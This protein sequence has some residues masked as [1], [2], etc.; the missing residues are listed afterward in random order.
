M[1]GLLTITYCKLSTEC[2]CENI[3]EIGPYLA[4]VWTKVSWHLF[5]AHGVCTLQK[6]HGIG[7]WCYD[8]DRHQNL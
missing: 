4:K 1:V 2:A 6:F 8:T 3:F 5:M 7:S